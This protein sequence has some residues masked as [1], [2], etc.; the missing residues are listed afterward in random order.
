[1]D[2]DYKAAQSLATEF[3]RKDIDSLTIR[4]HDALL[5][6]RKEISYAVESFWDSSR[7]AGYNEAC[8]K[9]GAMIRGEEYPPKSVSIGASVKE[10]FEGQ[11]K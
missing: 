2:D 1:M 5:R 3:F 11:F 4:I 8:L 9:M 10:L 6:Q 7:E